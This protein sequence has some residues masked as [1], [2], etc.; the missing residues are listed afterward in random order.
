MVK[1][2]EIKI[3][4]EEIKEHKLVY[5]KRS[6]VDNYIDFWDLVDQEEGMDGR[7]YS[8]QEPAPPP[9]ENI[10]PDQGRQGPARGAGQNPGLGQGQGGGNFNP[11]G[12]GY[13]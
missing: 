12:G 10:D 9:P 1:D 13:G 11:P 3:R 6:N 5:I 2:E 7:P 4:L 8:P